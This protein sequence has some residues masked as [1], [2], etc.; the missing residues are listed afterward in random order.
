MPNMANITVKKADGTTDVVYTALT[1]SA[2][3]KTPARWQ[4][5][6]SHAKAAL[7][8]TVEMTSR[9]NPAK[10][11]RHVTLL[12]K[13]PEVASVGGVDTVTGTGHMTI[14]G[15]IPLQVSDTAIAELV[16]QAAN[17]FKAA[18]VQ[19]S[20]KIGYAPQ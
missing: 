5:N 12:V 17:V 16:A 15:V 1:P 18:L 11:A 8:A 19:D 4:N 9:F 13:Y 3:D 14:D 2:G 20:F 7:R 6:A 10:T